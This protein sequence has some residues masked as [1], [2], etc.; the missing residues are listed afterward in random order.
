M[1]DKYVLIS[2]L[3]DKY[4]TKLVTAYGFEKVASGSAQEGFGAKFRNKTTIITIYFEM[5]TGYGEPFVQI[6]DITRQKTTSLG[7]LLEG[8]GIEKLPKFEDIH[9]DKL[10][11]I[12]ELDKILLQ[13]S[14]QLFTYATDFLKGDFSIM[15]KLEELEKK[16]QREY[17]EYRKSKSDL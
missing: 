10:K 2:Q 13:K 7:V 1:I 16:R 9:R 17:I 12:E 4:F 14:H 15:P 5:I 3:V 6:T 11:N 8:L